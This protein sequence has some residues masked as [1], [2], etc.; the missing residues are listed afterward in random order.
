M[1]V[2][3]RYY[4]KVENKKEVTFVISEP[5]RG[6]TEGIFRERLVKLNPQEVNS[7]TKQVSKVKTKFKMM[8]S[9]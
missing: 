9:R 4:L 5:S 2:K 1:E 3:K 6:T 7:K 8:S